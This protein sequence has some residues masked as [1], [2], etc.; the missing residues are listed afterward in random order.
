M[1][2]SFWAWEPAME[3]VRLQ[4]SETLELKGAWTDRALADLAAF[5]NTQGGTLILGVE[6]DGRVVGVQADDQEVQR[7]AN[8]ITSRLGITPSIR[9]EE[10]E[11]KAV[12]VIRVE[13]MRGLV[14]HNGRYLRR[15]GS[16]NRDFTQ[17]E[18]AR[19]L[20]ER[21]GLS[22]DSLPSDW[23][24]ED[25]DPSALRHFARLARPRLPWVDPADPERLLQNLQMLREG[26][27]TNAAILLFG[28]HPQRRF[29]TAQIR[30]GLFRG[31]TEIL[32]SHDFQG[33][34]WQ[35][36]EGAMERFRQVL[37]VRFD[38]HVDEPSLEGLQRKEVWE[39]PL[40]AL[41]EAVIN[42]LIHRDYTISAD[43]QI[44]I[45]EDRLEIWSVGE[46]LP[47]LTPE[48][49]RGPH[50]SLLRNP[51]LAQAFYF[52]GLVERWGTG[53]T[54]IIALCR[55]Q[56]LP[57]PEFEN[58]QGG[59]RVTFLKDPYTP[60]RLGALGLNDRQIR[61]V[62]YVKDKGSINNKTYQELT[63]VS[64]P[65]ATRDLEDMVRRGV[66]VKEGRTGRGTSYQLKGSERAQ[67]DHQG[68]KNGSKGSR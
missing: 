36:L 32:D 7:L 56:G 39:Y 6:D 55:E 41:R 65:T 62:M 33:P 46:L 38:V 18:L 23:T 67:R 16:T 15:V 51:L 50:G 49:L 61:A 53:T 21:S 11:G 64:K 8:L 47:P 24:P 1:Y 19:H 42:A 12:I 40:E 60:E 43:V 13:P 26:R 66:L 29:P 3:R 44:R 34:L 9:V 30:I 31:V 37:K 27:L 59:V 45:Y 58:W 2:S 52:A 54:R 14:P 48:S 17:E 68:L 28:K 20:L 25:V 22:W 57:E 5:A 63:G 10:M 4:E 35:Q